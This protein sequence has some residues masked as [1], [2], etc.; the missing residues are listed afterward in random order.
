MF[1]YSKVIGVHFEPSSKC[2]AACPQCPRNDNGGP[3]IDR[4]PEVMITAKDAEI[5]FPDDFVKQINHV[6]S[7]GNYGDPAFNPEL[8]D[9]YRRFR[10]LN[11]NMEL[12][13]HTNGGIQRP[14]W[15]DKLAKII[16]P[17]GFVT[18]GIDGLEDTNHIYRRNV[19]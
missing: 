8:V 1:D 5:I 13:V 3:T 6:Y 9:I 12:I 2:N 15:W 14:E 18:F 4:L 7:S 11:P 10:V 19:K 17:K 16:G